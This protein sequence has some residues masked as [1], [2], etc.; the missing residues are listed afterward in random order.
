MALILAAFLTAMALG[1]ALDLATSYLLGRIRRARRGRAG[2]GSGEAPP[3]PPPALVYSSTSTN[4]A[5][6]AV[7][8]A[9]CLTEFADG[10]AIRFM[11]A[12]RHG[13]HAH[14][15]DRWLAGGR[16]SSCPTCRAPTAVA[17]GA[18]A[19]TRLMR[20]RRHRRETVK[21]SLWRA[22]ALWPF[23]AGVRVY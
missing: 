22:S 14:C 9:I 6:A 8:C 16:H 19:A 12:C 10:D 17:T 13:F 4:L 23:L 18:A 11:P 21:G 2:S 15:I 20:P 7:E 1:L 3:P 5:G